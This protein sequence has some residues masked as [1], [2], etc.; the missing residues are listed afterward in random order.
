MVL[1]CWIQRNNRIRNLQLVG[2]GNSLSH[3]FNGVKVLVGDV[4]FGQACGFLSV[5]IMGFF[6]YDKYIE[7]PR[8]RKEC[9]H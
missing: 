1:W 8:R 6:V 5:F 9:I 4:H 3:T 7:C 2:I